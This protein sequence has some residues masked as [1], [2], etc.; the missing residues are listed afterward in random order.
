M[1]RHALLLVAVGLLIAADKAKNDGDKVLGGW[2]VESFMQSGQTVDDAK[3]DKVTFK[4]GK[5]E[6]KGKNGDHSGAYK[7]RPGA[8]PKQIDFTPDDGEGADKVHKGIYELKGDT[9]RVLL[10]GPDEDRPKN[11]KDKE[12]TGVIY[13]VLKRDKV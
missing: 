9:L 13:V 6:I 8:S 10:A 3:G 5:V 2:T 11:F 4:K 1:R 12:G 7:L